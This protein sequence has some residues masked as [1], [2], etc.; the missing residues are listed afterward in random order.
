MGVWPG[1]GVAEAAR[2][3]YTVMLVAVTFRRWK[4]YWL[5]ILLKD[6]PSLPEIPTWKGPK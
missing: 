2:L 5:T 3:T 4:L 1:G 6:T